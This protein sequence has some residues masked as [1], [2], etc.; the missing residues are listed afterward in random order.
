MHRNCYL[1]GLFLALTFVVLHAR[2]VPYDL[3]EQIDDEPNSNT[4]EQRREIFFDRIPS[5]SASNSKKLI[6]HIGN[7]H[8]YPYEADRSMAFARRAKAIVKGDP[9]EFMG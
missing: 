4:D 8:N 9:R 2:N 6:I 7:E 3:I 1:V 5:K